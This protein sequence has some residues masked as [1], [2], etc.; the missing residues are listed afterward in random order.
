VLTDHVEDMEAEEDLEEAM[1]DVMTA[2]QEEEII[3][4]DATMIVHLEEEDRLPLILEEEVLHQEE[5]A[6]H[7]KEEM[8]AEVEVQLKSEALP[9]AQVQ[10]ENELLPDQDLL[11][12]L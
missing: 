5:E 2:R 1:E 9:V 6:L 7:Q 4:Q 3:V 8:I 10:E 12:L 11:L